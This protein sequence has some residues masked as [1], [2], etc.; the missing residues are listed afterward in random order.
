MGNDKPGLDVF[1]IY[2]AISR[3]AGMPTAGA[4]RPFFSHTDLSYY[5]GNPNGGDDEKICGDCHKI[6]CACSE[7]NNDAV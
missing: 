6:V 5:G 3:S 1:A 2:G 4:A 7:E